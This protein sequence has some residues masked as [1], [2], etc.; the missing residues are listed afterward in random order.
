MCD[1]FDFNELHKSIIDKILR[2][3]KKCPEILENEE[4]NTDTSNIVNNVNKIAY[5]ELINNRK[6]MEMQFREYQKYIKFNNDKF[7]YQRFIEPSE[8]LIKKQ[9]EYQLDIQNKIQDHQ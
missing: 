8:Y 3:N 5:F 6:L 1:Y 4:V 7:K 9:Y 2:R